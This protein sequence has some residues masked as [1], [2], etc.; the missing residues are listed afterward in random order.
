MVEQL[1]AVN[2]DFSEYVLS[3][4]AESEFEDLRDIRQFE[5]LVMFEELPEEQKVGFRVLVDKFQELDEEAMPM[6]DWIY[7][8]VVPGEYEIWESSQDRK[9][10]QW[11]HSEEEAEQKYVDEIKQNKLDEQ[12][13]DELELRNQLSE[14]LSEQDERCLDMDFDEAFESRQKD[15]P[16]IREIERELKRINPKGESSKVGTRDYAWC[17]SLGNEIGQDLAYLWANNPL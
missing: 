5:L 1:C 3:V 13:F 2:R 6:A 16:R 7:Y 15:I 10:E 17:L 14:I 8:I 11:V 12:E 9:F 4:G